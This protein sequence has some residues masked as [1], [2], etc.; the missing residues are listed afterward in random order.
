MCVCGGGEG[1]GENS[2]TVAI[3]LVAMLTTHT[4]TLL[5]HVQ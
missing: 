2:T 3:S 4:Y 5:I 1:G